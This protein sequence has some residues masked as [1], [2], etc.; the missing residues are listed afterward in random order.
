MESEREEMQWQSRGT[1]MTHAGFLLLLEAGCSPVLLSWSRE[2]GQSC[3]DGAGGGQ[4]KSLPDKFW[5]VVSKG[6]QAG[7]MGNDSEL[8][9]GSRIN[10]P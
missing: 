2:P 1:A 5:A 6:R 4:E 3:Q 7:L 9:Q 10:I 8:L